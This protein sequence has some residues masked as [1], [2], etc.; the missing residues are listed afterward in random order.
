MKI[1]WIKYLPF[2]KAAG[3]RWIKKYPSRTCLTDGSWS[4]GTSDLWPHTPAMTLTC[5][6]TPSFPVPSSCLLHNFSLILL[7]VKG[8]SLLW[9]CR[10]K[11]LVVNSLKKKK[12][13]SNYLFLYLLSKVDFSYTIPIFGEVPLRF[14]ATVNHKGR[15]HLSLHLTIEGLSEVI[16]IASAEHLCSW[17]ISFGSACF[18][19]L[20]RP[21]ACLFIDGYIWL[22]KYYQKSIDRWHCMY[23]CHKIFVLTDIMNQCKGRGS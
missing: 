23:Y 18:P 7:L 2:S 13:N 15:I 3:C 4:L 14:Y 1:S 6:G 21:G 11:L 16:R 12:K 9:W 22:Q 19:A 17:W 8:S 5:F 10:I 20:K